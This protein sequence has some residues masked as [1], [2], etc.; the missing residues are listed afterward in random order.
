LKRHTWVSS[1]SRERSSEYR[2]EEPFFLTRRSLIY[3]PSGAPAQKSYFRDFFRFDAYHR[4]VQNSPILHLKREC[5]MDL[6]RRFLIVAILCSATAVAAAEELVGVLPVVGSTPG[7]FGSYFKTELQLNNRSAQPMSGRMVFHSLGTPATSADRS[8]EYSLAPHQTI[9]YSDVVELLGATGLGSIDL[10]PNGSGMPVV[11]ARAFDDKGVEGTT[12]ASIPLVT[13]ADF[14]RV[15]D[16]VI[17]IAPLDRAHFRFNIGVRSLSEGASL[18][19]AVY[20]PQGVGLKTLELAH[21]EPNY[22]LQRS[23][24]DFL[25]MTLT[26]DESIDIEIVTGSAIVYGTMTDNATNDPSLQLAVRRGAL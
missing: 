10:L 2:D 23:A 26:G 9:V 11:F 17:L 21:Y 18:R 4:L 8:L 19:V 14:G 16:H 1:Y 15:G 20:S 3:Y 7:A 22:L 5:S 24:E 25:G 13:A 12:G 6:S